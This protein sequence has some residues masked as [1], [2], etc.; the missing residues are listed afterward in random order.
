M[1]REL[2]VQVGTGSLQRSKTDS[3]ATAVAERM[4]GERFRTLSAGAPARLAGRCSRDHMQQLVLN[5]SDGMSVPVMVS[6]GVDPGQGFVELVG[7]KGPQNELRVTSFSRF[8]SDEVDL[9]LWNQALQLSQAPA[10]RQLFKP[11]EANLPQGAP[12]GFVA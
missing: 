1:I 7:T 2:V 11:P 8:Q 6:P 4:N 3:M 10:L 9:E 5:S 12:M